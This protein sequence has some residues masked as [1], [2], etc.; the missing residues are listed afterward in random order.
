[1]NVTNL[2]ML[3]LE[4]LNTKANRDNIRPGVYPI[5]FTVRVSGLLTVGED[6]L[7]TPTCE[8]P[9]LK[10]I[11]VALS[12]V[13]SDVREKI[14]GKIEKAVEKAFEDGD[15]FEN[16]LSKAVKSRAEEIRRRFQARLPKKPVKGA[17]KLA[18]QV[19]P[20]AVRRS[21]AKAE[22]SAPVMTLA[23]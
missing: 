22:K 12:M 17:V 18:V 9:V 6:S 20:V 14:L 1:M 19:E 8:I 2:E 5:D 4:K 23:A 15:K 11:A 3:A 10:V 16:E 7:R 21:M 13:D